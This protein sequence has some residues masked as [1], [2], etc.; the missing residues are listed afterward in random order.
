MRFIGT[1]EIAL[2]LQIVRRI[3]EYQIDR[4]GLQL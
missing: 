2:Q 1:L 3:R 4:T